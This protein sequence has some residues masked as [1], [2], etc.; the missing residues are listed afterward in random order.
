MWSKKNNMLTSLDNLPSAEEIDS[1][2]N[3]KTNL[4]QLWNINEDL[5]WMKM[6]PIKIL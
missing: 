2:S 3:T 5:F 4:M 1:T 6:K